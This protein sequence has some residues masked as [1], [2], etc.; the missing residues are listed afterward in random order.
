MAGVLHMLAAGSQ[1]KTREQILEHGL[2]LQYQKYV[3]RRN[4]F[5]YSMLVDSYQKFIRAIQGKRA[6]QYECK[7]F[8]GLYHQGRGGT[9]K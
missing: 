9:K 2:G 4:V 6:N 7:I 1:G 8:N 3:T 5:K